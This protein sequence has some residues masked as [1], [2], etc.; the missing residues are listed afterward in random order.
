MDVERCDKYC[1]NMVKAYGLIWGQCTK[2]VKNKLEARKDWN[3]GA[4]KIKMNLFALLK[5]L[6]EITHNH[7]DYRYIMESMY[8]CM[9]NV[10]TVKQDENE[11]I[12]DFTRR[13]KN[14]V[15]VMEN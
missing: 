9:K 2:G 4:T 5:A 7:Q 8:N 13:F 10:F 14:T 1:I 11:N 3:D 6:K 12:T 15:E